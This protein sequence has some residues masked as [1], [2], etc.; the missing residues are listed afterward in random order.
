MKKA[1]RPTAKK[2]DIPSWESLIA[3]KQAQ[4][5]DTYKPQRIEDASKR[6]SAAATKRWRKKNW[7]HYRAKQK[8]W[9][10]ANPEKKKLYQQRNK[11]NIKRWAQ[12]HPER[13]RELGRKSDAKRRNSERRKAWAEE[14][15][16]RPEVIERRRERERL[17]AKD[18]K[19]IA[20]R[21]AYEEKRKNDPNRIAYTK[22]YNRKYNER[23]K[24]EKAAG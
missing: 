10:A 12:E 9:L 19:R 5:R 23:K 1:T 4:H 16:T 2:S 11:K 17:R 20:W 13:I 18:P 24:L 21:K 14:Y 15:K 22:E 7:E 6:N 3:Q 8:E